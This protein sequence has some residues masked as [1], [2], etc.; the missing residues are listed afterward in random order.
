VENKTTEFYEVEPYDEFE[1][2]SRRL[3][4]KK[5]FLSLPAQIRELVG[6]FEKGNFDGTIITQ[7]DEPVHYE[8]YKL[9]LPNH[10]TGM[11]KSNGY[12]VVYV[13]ITDT[14]IVV[15]ITIYYKKERETIA[16]HEIKL[17]IEGYFMNLHKE[18]DYEGDL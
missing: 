12:R 7:G 18:E 13:V 1:K 17:L 8:V 4:R 6:E 3:V 16:E 10:D 5:K 2:E 15:L 11:G 14:K 9:R